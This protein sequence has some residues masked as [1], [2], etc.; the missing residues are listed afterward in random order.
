MLRV[1]NLK[2][3][4][5]FNAT[6]GEIFGDNVGANTMRDSMINPLSYYALAKSIS[7]EISADLIEYN[8]N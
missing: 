2:N 4:K 5:I 1:N 6:S 7:L 8:L 3:I